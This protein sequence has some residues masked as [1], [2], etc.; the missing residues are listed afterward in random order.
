MAYKV[1]LNL[2]CITVHINA[3]QDVCYS[4]ENEACTLLAAGKHIG[5]LPAAAHKKSPLPAA[6]RGGLQNSLLAGCIVQ[7]HMMQQPRCSCNRGWPQ[8]SERSS[9]L[10]PKRPLRATCAWQ[11]ILL[12]ASCCMPAQ[13]SRRSPSQRL[14]GWPAP[15]SACM[16]GGPAACKGTGILL[17]LQ[18]TASA[19]SGQPPAQTRTC[20]QGF[21]YSPVHQV[22]SCAASRMFVAIATKQLPLAISCRGSLQ[23]DLLA[24]RVVQQ[25][26]MQQACCMRYRE[27]P[28]PGQGSCQLRPKGVFRN[29]LHH[30]QQT[31]SLCCM[32]SSLLDFLLYVPIECVFW[33]KSWHH[34]W[35]S[36]IILSQNC[37]R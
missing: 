14:Q 19:W 29:F 27:R 6:C 16:P 12:R 34:S 35:V 3:S 23:H 20:L 4:D 2:P 37:L 9:Q 33:L 32:Q 1:T 18:G 10:T 8:S 13:C 28:K 24:D 17:G 26:V 7:Q 31:H 11:P 5:K 36:G 15:H 30:K 25:R 21:L 22:P